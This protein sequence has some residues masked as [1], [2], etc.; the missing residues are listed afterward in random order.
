VDLLTGQAWSSG[1]MLAG[2]G[3]AVVRRAN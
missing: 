3:V 1:D 2:G